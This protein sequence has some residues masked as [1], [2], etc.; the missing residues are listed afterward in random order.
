MTAGVVQ[1]L[2]VSP[3]L[4]PELTLGRV[5]ELRAKC[6]VPGLFM[7]SEVRDADGELHPDGA[8]KILAIDEQDDGTLRFA[9]DNGISLPFEPDELVTMQCLVLPCPPW[10][11]DHQN[12]AECVH[13][14]SEIFEVEAND[15]GEV[16]T[17]SAY[18]FDDP[19]GTCEPAAICLTFGAALIGEA[20][21][22]ITPAQARALGEFLVRAADM[23]EGVSK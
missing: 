16:M 23:I 12:D 14:G 4:S 7:P 1:W 3:P 15:A 8:A 22:A 11:V 17:V 10:C 9:F 2:P 6:M 21:D 5:V 18:R 13:H 20:L 19:D